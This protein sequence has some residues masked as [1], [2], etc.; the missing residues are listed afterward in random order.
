MYKTPSKFNPR[1]DSPYGKDV[2]NKLKTLIISAFDNKENKDLNDV[3]QQI[4]NGM[5]TALGFVSHD[6]TFMC[7][8]VN[9]HSYD[10]N[11]DEI[12]LEMMKLKTGGFYLEWLLNDDCYLVVKNM[13]QQPYVERSMDIPDEMLKKMESIDPGEKEEII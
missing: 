2:S 5:D 10:K 1:C 9:K 11:G 4:A 6:N 12:I 8:I 7:A 3:C 13:Y